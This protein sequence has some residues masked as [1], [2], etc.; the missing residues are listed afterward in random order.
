M[1]AQL[2]MATVPKTLLRV[3]FTVSVQA[4]SIA[5]IH[6]PIGNKITFRSVIT[7][8]Y[9]IRS[10]KARYLSKAIA[11]EVK[12][13]TVP[14][15]AAIMR[16]GLQSRQYSE[17]FFKTTARFKTS[18]SGVTRTPTPRSDHTRLHRRAFDGGWGWGGSTSSYSCQ[19]HTIFKSGD[20]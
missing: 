7:C 10:R 1:T 15:T 8:R 20:N 18:Y 17:G 9:F 13:D 12:K 19:N 6:S 16:N 11:V 3:S 4:Q 14:I 2:N 5:K